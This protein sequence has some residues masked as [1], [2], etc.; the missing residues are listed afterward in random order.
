MEDNARLAFGVLDLN[1]FKQLIYILHRCK[2]SGAE[3]E[4]G[5]FY[6][7]DSV[8]HDIIQIISVTNNDQSRVLNKS[9]I[10]QRVIIRC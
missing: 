1:V 8:F 2:T 3:F 10:L 7:S 9:K 6:I 5:I 4:I